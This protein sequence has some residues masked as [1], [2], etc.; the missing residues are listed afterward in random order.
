[1]GSIPLEDNFSDIVGKAQRGLKLSDADLAARAGIAPE[2]VA[3]VK[4]GAVDE[5][6]LRKLAPALNLAAEALVQSAK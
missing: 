3:Q 6:A 2:A 5:A 4:G 1:M